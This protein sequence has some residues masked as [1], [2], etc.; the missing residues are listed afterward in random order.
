MGRKENA[1]IEY[2]NQKQRF[3]ELVN[4]FL[5]E[6]ESYLRAEELED[7][8]RRQEHGSGKKRKTLRHRYRDVSKRANGLKVH[9]VIGAEMQEHVDYAM[10]LRSMDMDTLGYLGQKKRI[11]EMYLHSESR[12]SGDEY[13]SRFRKSDRLIPEVT[14]VL[15]LG[16]QPW[17]GARNLYELLDFER[18]PE[19]ARKY[20]QNYN[21]HILDVKHTADEEFQKY[22]RDI[23]FLLMFIKYTEDKEALAKLGELTG[24]DVIDT[25]TFDALTEYTNEPELMKWKEKEEKDGE[26]SMC[27]GI[28]DL[29]ADGRAEGKAEGEIKKLLELI[30]KKI[31]KGKS[32]TDTA[33]E[34]EETEEN[35]AGLYN[36]VKSH[37]GEPMEKLLDLI[38]EQ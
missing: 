17:D 4:E 11:S 18:V 20:I 14:L 32:L 6:G 2:C 1:L 8:D 38:K 22:P 33:E 12:L 9:L 36:L 31:Q 28:R 19:K 23:R 10:V 13:L 24:C 21:L 35:I 26:V 3:A 37:P 7:A 25:D 15:Y 16:E 5:F 29:V 30:Q 27:K 34:L